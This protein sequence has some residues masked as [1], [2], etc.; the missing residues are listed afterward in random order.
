MSLKQAI[1]L[2]ESEY[3]RAKTLEFVRNPLAYAL[4]KVWKMADASEEEVKRSCTTCAYGGVPKYKS[5]CSECS[6]MSEY[7]KGG[8]SDGG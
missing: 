6:N 8:C 1:K 4:H 3:E 5:P 7:K 2:V